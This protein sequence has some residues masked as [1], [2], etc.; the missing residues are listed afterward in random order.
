MWPFFDCISASWLKDGS[1]TGRCG[2]CQFNGR[3]CCYEDSEFGGLR[4]LRRWRSRTPASKSALW[5]VSSLGD[6]LYEAPSSRMETQ[7]D[8]KGVTRP[9]P[10]RGTDRGTGIRKGKK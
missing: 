6:R 3:T 4:R 2:N 5:E 1:H 8:Q 7:W 10:E 9:K